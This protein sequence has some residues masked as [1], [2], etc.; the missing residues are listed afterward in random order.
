MRIPDVLK[1]LYNYSQEFNGIPSVKD[2][3]IASVFQEVYRKIGSSRKA[4]YIAGVIQNER[5]KKYPQM[6]FIVRAGKY[7]LDERSKTLLKKIGVFNLHQKEK[8]I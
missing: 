1:A 8:L 6:T 7:E 4:L 5:R 2:K 3:R